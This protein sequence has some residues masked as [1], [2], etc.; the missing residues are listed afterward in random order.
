MGLAGSYTR[1]RVQSRRTQS[2]SWQPVRIQADIPGHFQAGSGQIFCLPKTR[3]VRL[4]E[5]PE[6]VEPR[7]TTTGQAWLITNA[8]PHMLVHH[9][10]IGS[11]RETPQTHSHPRLNPSQGRACKARC[12]T[13]EA[14]RPLMRGLPFMLMFHSMFPGKPFI[15]RSALVCSVS[16]W[17]HLSRRNQPHTCNWTSSRSLPFSIGQPVGA[18]WYALLESRLH[19][20]AQLHVCRM[21]ASR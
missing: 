13:W 10:W 16:T 5:R 15:L 6:W 19:E 8:W 4:T 1:P 11:S 7:P 12:G 9:T 3:Q 14:Y 2:Q 21:D 18:P 17:I 20:F